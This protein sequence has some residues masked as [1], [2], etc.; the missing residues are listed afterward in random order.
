MKIWR[1][2]TTP[3]TGKGREGRPSNFWEKQIDPGQ[4]EYVSMTKDDFEKYVLPLL[5][6]K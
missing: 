4:V 6:K 1:G 3:E 5:E 2:W